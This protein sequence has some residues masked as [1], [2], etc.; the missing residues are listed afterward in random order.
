MRG[1]VA[2]GNQRHSRELSA[3]SGEHDRRA[4]GDRVGDGGERPGGVVDDGVRAAAPAAGE[5]AQA[6]REHRWCE[7]SHRATRACTR[8]ED[9]LAQRAVGDAELA[10]DVVRAAPLDG[11]RDEGLALA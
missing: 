3:G 10:R 5:R 6:E 9:E 2:A 1:A 4:D 11:G 7:G 8:A